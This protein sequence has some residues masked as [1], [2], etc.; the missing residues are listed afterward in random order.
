[1]NVLIA[2]DY[3]KQ[4]IGNNFHTIKLQRIIDTVSQITNHNNSKIAYFCTYHLIKLKI[5]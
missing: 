4:F 5:N 2:K 3:P 1:M